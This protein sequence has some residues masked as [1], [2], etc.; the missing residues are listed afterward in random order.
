VVFFL[1]LNAASSALTLWAG[2]AWYGY[3]YFLSAAATF[4][5][6]YVIM[7]RKIAT[8]PYLVFV[9]INPSVKRG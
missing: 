3:G 7:L 1:L 4:S 2:F 6:A 8:L 5:I 9:E